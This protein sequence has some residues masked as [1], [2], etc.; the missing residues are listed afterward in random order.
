MACFKEAR[1]D[2]IACS[3]GNIKESQ[4]ELFPLSV[5]E[6]TCEKRAERS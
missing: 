6:H 5:K 1:T 3:E 4:T 2:P